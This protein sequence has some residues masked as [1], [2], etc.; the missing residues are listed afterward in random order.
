MTLRSSLSHVLQTHHSVARK[1]LFTNDV[2]LLISRAMD[3]FDSVHTFSFVL[4][5]HGHPGSMIYQLSP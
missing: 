3:T 1:V 5:D 4:E 2:F